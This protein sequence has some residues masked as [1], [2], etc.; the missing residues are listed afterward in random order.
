MELIKA[1]LIITTFK[2][3]KVREEHDREEVSSPPE[4]TLDRTARRGQAQALT[5]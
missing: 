3:L 1:K 4:L 2:S 5:E